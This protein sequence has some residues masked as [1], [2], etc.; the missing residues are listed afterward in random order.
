MEELEETEKIT[1]EEAPTQ[2]VLTDGK[3]DLFALAEAVIL[4][5]NGKE[6]TQKDTFL[7]YQLTGEK[8]PCHKSLRK[9]ATDILIRHGDKL[10]AA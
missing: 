3:G 6:F 2:L 10:D 8:Y 5:F 4:L 1:T 7:F 9:F